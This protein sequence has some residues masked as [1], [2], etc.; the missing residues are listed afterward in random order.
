ME[1]NKLDN[2]HGVPCGITYGQHERVDE[3]N[4]RIYSR[5]FSDIPLAPNFDPRPVPTKYSLFPIVNRRTESSVKINPA[6]THQ[7][8]LNF[9][10]GTRNA[11]SAGYFNNIDVETTLRNQTVALQHG[12][13]QGVY[14]P[15]VKSDLYNVHVPSTTGVSQPYPQLFR[16]ETYKTTISNNLVNS[17]IGVDRFNNYTRTQLRKVEITNEPLRTIT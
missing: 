2:I 12:A 14:I 3:L 16:S 8:E 17:K 1:Y 13:E 6:I 11:P 9:N 5:N 15:S 7:V 10:P 4:D